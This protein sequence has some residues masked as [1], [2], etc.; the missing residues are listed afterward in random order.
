MTTTASYYYGTGKRKCAIARVRLY[1]N[2]DGSIII[3]GKPL[4]EALPWV[5]WQKRATLPFERI[6]EVANRFNVVAKIEGGGISAWADAVRHGIA[7]ALLVADPTLRPVLRKNGFLTRDS[8]IKESKK[9][10]LK[11]ARRAKQYTKR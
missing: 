6:P 2:G 7:R 10:G 1:P 4:A 8:R 9:Y 5:D 3:N 11:R